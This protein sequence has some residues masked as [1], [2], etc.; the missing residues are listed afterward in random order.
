M[1]SAFAGDGLEPRSGIGLVEVDADRDE[2]ALLRDRVPRDVDHRPDEVHEEP[3]LAARTAHPHAALHAVG[4]VRRILEQVDER[5]RLDGARERDGRRMRVLVRRRLLAQQRR[6]RQLIRRL[7]LRGDVEDERGVDAAL[8][9]GD[10]GRARV[11]RPDP[12]ADPREPGLAVAGRQQI[13]LADHDERRGSVPRGQVLPRVDR[14]E[15]LDRVDNLDDAARADPLGAAE[16]NEPREG[17]RV[18]DAARLDDDRVEAQPRIG[19]PLERLVEPARVG[20]AAHAPAR[21]RGRLVDLAHDKTRVNVQRAEVV[22]DDADARA[23][24]AQEVV[25][26]RRLARAEM[27]RQRDDGNAWSR[28]TPPPE[29]VSQ[30]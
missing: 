17:D 6:D 19:Q 22:H 25:E 20:Q 23:R 2:L 24:G 7:V 1:P 12:L 8:A 15:V 30:L 27:A 13:G 16:S 26:Q 3:L 4:A 21:D 9:H 14:V 5:G 18:G 11:T 10:D 28:H 29:N